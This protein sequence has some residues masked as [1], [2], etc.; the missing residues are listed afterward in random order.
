[1]TVGFLFGGVFK[2]GAYGV[3]VAGAGCFQGLTGGRDAAAVGRGTTAAVVDGI[4]L[5][6]AAGGFFAVLFYILGI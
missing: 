1:V 3:L 4:V 5:V 6:I 2:A